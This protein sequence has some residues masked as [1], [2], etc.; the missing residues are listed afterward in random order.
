MMSAIAGCFKKTDYPR[1][2]IKALLCFERLLKLGEQ[3]KETRNLGMNPFVFAL[4]N[5]GAVQDFEYLQK[6]SNERV[7]GLFAKIVDEY[8]TG[9]V[10]L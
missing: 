7:Y 4:E 8:F 5:E 10:T 3:L 1:V 6:H 9:L 2:I